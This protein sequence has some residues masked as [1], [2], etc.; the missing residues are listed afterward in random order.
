MPSPIGPNH[1]GETGQGFE[2]TPAPLASQQPAEGAYRKST[3]PTAQRLPWS[4]DPWCESTGLRC[5]LGPLWVGSSVPL[6]VCCPEGI[7]DVWGGDGYPQRKP[8]RSVDI[9]FDSGQT[10]STQPNRGI[11]P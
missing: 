2:G 4:K 10:S 6:G 8:L 11:H 3:A 9:R 1:G 5:S 7:Y